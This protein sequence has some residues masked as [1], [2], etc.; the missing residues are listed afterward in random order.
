MIHQFLDIR[1]LLYH[2]ISYMYLSLLR[3]LFF[4]SYRSW[5]DLLHVHLVMNNVSVHSG[6]HTSTVS[7]EIWLHS[8]W[9]PYMITILSLS[10][11]VVFLLVLTPCNILVYTILWNNLTKECNTSASEMEFVFFNL[12]FS[13]L[14]ICS[15]LHSIVLHLEVEQSSE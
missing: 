13:F 15:T 3:I 9:W 6:L 2:R 12:R 8:S 5:Y 1:V 4:F 7:S 14:H 10:W 11:T